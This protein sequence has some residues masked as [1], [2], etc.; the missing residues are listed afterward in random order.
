MFIFLSLFV[1]SRICRVCVRGVPPAVPRV[2]PALLAGHHAVLGRHQ[3][4]GHADEEGGRAQGAAAGG[5]D[6]VPAREGM[7]I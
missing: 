1:F 2:P 7:T 3:P 4:V 6:E 5:E